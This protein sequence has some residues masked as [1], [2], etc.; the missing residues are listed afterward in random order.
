M[1]QRDEVYSVVVCGGGLTG[2]CG[3]SCRQKR[4]RHLPD[5][6]QTCIRGQQL[7]RGKVIPY[8]ERLGSIYARV[9]GAN[10][11][12]PESRSGSFEPFSFP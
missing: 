11:Q 3:G 2:F 9:P 12:Y 5:S 4:S 6:R 1:L 8:G 10:R 7:V